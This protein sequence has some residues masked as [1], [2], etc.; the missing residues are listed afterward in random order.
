[1]NIYSEKTKVSGAVLTTMLSQFKELMQIFGITFGTVELVDAKIEEL[2]EER[3]EARSNKDFKKSDE[4][5]ELLKTEGIIL[6]DTPQGTRWRR[7]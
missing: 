6:D 5:R 2:I 3:N 1:M 4:I 7:E